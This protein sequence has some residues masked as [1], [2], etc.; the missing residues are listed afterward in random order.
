L[1]LKPNFADA[2]NNLGIGFLD[3]GETEKAIDQFRD[4]LK[5][6]PGYTYARINLGVA[7]AKGGQVEEAI[8]QYREVL[9]YDPDNAKL[10]NNLGL[11]LF[12]KGKWDEAIIQ[13]RDALKINPNA[14]LVCN[15]LGLALYEKG[16]VDEAIA[17]Y[18]KAL[19]LKPGYL[20]ALNNLA[21]ML[22]TCPE[23]RLR[24]GV[25][26]VQLAQ[27]AAQLDGGENP[28]TLRTLA[29]AYAEAGKFAQAVETARRAMQL[30]SAQGNTPLARTLEQEL[31]LYQI[32]TPMRDVKQ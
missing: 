5:I 15:N 16:R 10:H 8:M 11:A 27:K 13:Y 3:M 23:T 25:E 9:K 19:Q 18:R 1:E 20:D 32:D 6:N 12:Q 4:A 31:E 24:N 14:D 26:A 28:P 29:A 22:A 2:R 17:E 7:L 30:A 21:W